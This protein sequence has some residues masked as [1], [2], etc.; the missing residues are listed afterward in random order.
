MRFAKPAATDA[1]LWQALQIAQLSD[2]V[3][4][5]PHQLDAAIDQGA[6]NLAGGQRQRL[7]IA[8][9]L[10]ARTRIYLIDDCL[11]ALDGATEARLRTSLRAATA[12]A[13]VIMA[14]QRVAVAADADQIVVL[15]DGRIAGPG[16]HRQLLTDCATYREIVMSQLGE[17]AS[18]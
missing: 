3:Q 2:F 15:D 6:T 18:V 11:A 14:T 7:S 12:G 17:E 1:E 5:L 8:R 10:L 4:R 16:E 9:V 13:T